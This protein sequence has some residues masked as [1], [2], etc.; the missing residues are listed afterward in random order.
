[1]KV[2][3]P[4]NEDR[5]LDSAV[6][7]HFGSAPGFLMVD[8]ATGDC[9][10]IANENQHHGHGMCQPLQA[11]AGEQVDGMVVGGIGMGAV[12]KL[13]AAGVAVYK[14]S[15]PT[16]RETLDAL[17]AGTLPTVTADMACGQHGHAQG[18]GGGCGHGQG[19]GGK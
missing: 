7:E 4:I 18:Q 12:N 16:V 10:A 2:C 9:R 5:G 13:M 14:S 1:M 8:T 3:I 19:N 17:A 15:F 11:L 6:C